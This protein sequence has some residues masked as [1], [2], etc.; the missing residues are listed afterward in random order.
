MTEDNFLILFSFSFFFP[1][2]HK[3]AFYFCGIP[4]LEGKMRSSTSS[5]TLNKTIE[6]HWRLL[7]CR[8]LHLF[9]YWSVTIGIKVLWFCFSISQHNVAIP[10][11][12][13]MLPI[14]N[15]QKLPFS[16]D[17]V[18]PV[19]CALCIVPTDPDLETCQRNAFLWPASSSSNLIS[20]V[21]RHDADNLPNFSSSAMDLKC[22][23]YFSAA[24]LE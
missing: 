7:V 21:T 13:D 6:C 14:V 18:S 16:Q 23:H 10:L 12:V 20:Q 5:N 17:F 24:S 8:F 11:K 1:L 22:K 19:T 2:F 3:D 9:H 15:L 4:L